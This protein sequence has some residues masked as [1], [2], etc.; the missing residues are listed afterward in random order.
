M[1]TPERPPD[2]TLARLE[3]LLLGGPPSLTLPQV[4]EQAGVEPAQVA[5]FWRALGLPV[6]DPDVAAFTPTD[7]LVVETVLRAGREFDLSGRTGVTLV[8][9]IGHTTERLVTW[10]VESLVE[11]M[12]FRYALDDTTA[13]ILVLD[14]LADVVPLLEL[15]LVHAWRRQVA[16]IAGRFAQT[17]AQAH[18]PKQTDD[19][20]LARAMGFADMVSFTTRSAGLGPGALAELVGGFEAAARDTVTALG[21]RVVKTIG[22]A[23][24]FVADDIETGAR[25]ALGLADAL[26]AGS[27][28]PVRVG[29]TW[30]RV[31]SRFGDVFGPSVNVAARMTAQAEP[32]TV[33]LDASTGA[34]LAGRAGFA[35]APQ[36]EREV[37][38]LGPVSP[39]RLSRA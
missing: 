24:L 35:L 19:L 38:G 9:A 8:R 25:V 37:A 27:S 16:A 28:T 13:R 32:G 33:M 22:D 12:A 14:R 26:G 10:Q 11:H 31:I 15:Q 36:P 2:S 5:A 20:P 7:A 23:V 29:L 6:P 17:Y 4:A 18:V 39:V 21:G 30:G 34:H 1:E 3:E